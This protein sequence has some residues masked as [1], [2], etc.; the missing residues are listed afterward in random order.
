[1]K[2]LK[3]L[4]GSLSQNQTRTLCRILAAGALLLA[5]IL[6]EPEGWWNLLYLAP[7]FLAG[8][9]VLLRSGRNILRGQVFDENF[10]MTLATFGALALGQY[11]EAVFVMLFYQVG[12]LFQSIAVGHSRASVAALMDIRPETANLWENGAL[13]E[14]DPAEVAAG[15]RIVVKP[16]E[17]IPLDGRVIE[18][19]SS[20]DTAALT[21]ESFPRDVAAGDEVVSGC[22]NGQGMLLIEVSRPYEES[23]VARILELV[24]NSADN[25][26]RTERFITS[27]ARWYTPAV[28]VAAILLAVLPPLL[29]FGPF[30]DWVY[31]ALG[32]LVV[33]CP[34]AVV[35]SVPMSYF[36]GIGGASRRGILVK[37]AN[38]MDALGRCRTAVF[39]KTGT[40]TRGVFSVAELYPVG[41]DEN[42][43][44][45]LA[46]AAESGSDH[47]IAKSLR[48]AC[49]ADLSA[50]PVSDVT[51]VPGR[52]L[53]AR[54]SGHS[55]AVGNAQMMADMG[56]SVETPEEP[57]TVV[58]VVADGRYIGCIRI[59]DELRPAA[60]TALLD[61]RRLG[62]ARTL[63]LSGDRR[64]NAEAIAREVGVDEVRAELLPQEKSRELEALLSAPH[65][66]TV[67][68]VGDG[69][70]DAPCIA[71]AD[72]GIA[73]GG[74]GSDAAI[75]A[76]DV[77]LMDDD[78]G[79][80][81][82]AIRIARRTRRIVLENI[83]FSLAVK[84][85]ALA[86]VALNLVGLWAAVF[87]DVGVAVVATL[88]AL[89][90]LYVKR[91]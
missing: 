11:P 22:V 83:V 30:S 36:G 15:D 51:E 50:H 25:K 16:G 61:L 8:Y 56:A 14:V 67:A 57:G 65:A 9:D 55:V 2:R 85:A 21:G 77:V 35:I 27:F 88:N 53:M 10:L 17:R 64:E 12:E 74:L 1:M 87:A 72:V 18:G 84:A 75:E 29:G 13:R 82:L 81:P 26:A 28:V 39:D 89:R 24:E 40:L 62:V 71:L 49:T 34:C 43:L 58:Y 23:T 19:A 91:A 68:Y 42:T 7:Y 3:R 59:A 52:G 45:A 47:P 44:L 70:N 80:L 54:V 37:G 60:K 5:L 63:I 79:K 20:L 33:S 90:A 38:Y 31:R 32:F 78:P 48:A 66:G 46:A 69:V 4:L 73:M 41:V 86:L 6:A 76:A